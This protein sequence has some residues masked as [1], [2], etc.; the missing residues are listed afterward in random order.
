MSQPSDVMSWTSG[1]L[2]ASKYGVPHL[3]QWTQVQK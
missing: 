1:V 3:E 2:F